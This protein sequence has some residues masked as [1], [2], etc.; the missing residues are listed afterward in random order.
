[1][2]K[3]KCLNCLI[4]FEFQRK[5]R[6]FCNNSCSLDFRK[7]QKLRSLVVCNSCKIE[8]NRSEFWIKCPKLQ[9]IHHECKDCGCKR[10]KERSEEWRLK[11]RIRSRN[12]ERVKR[13]IPLDS[14]L[15]KKRDGSGYID[16]NGY[17]ML[18]RPGHPNCITK[19]GRIAEHTFVMSKHLGRPLFKNENVHHK[20][21]MRSDNR[22]ENLELWIRKQPYGQRVED[23]ISWC[24]D[25]LKQ[26][27]PEKLRND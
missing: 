13:G 22:I 15:L 25:F 17:R 27:A 6:K 20:N 2:Y 3:F 9:R 1:M 23:K 11:E 8:K 10:I 24:V 5:N 16:Q 19:D 21:G 4:E 12:R 7:K 18:M 14:P 26:Y